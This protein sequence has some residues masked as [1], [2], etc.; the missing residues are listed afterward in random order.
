MR[1]GALT[2]LEATGELQDRYQVWLCRCD[3]GNEIKASTKRLRRVPD[4]SCGCTKID[5][6]RP[7]PIPCDLTGRRYGMLTV[8]RSEPSAKAL[9]PSWLCRCDCGNECY[10][11]SYSLHNGKRKSCG[12]LHR[13]ASSARDVDLTDQVF[14]RLTAIC[15]TEDRGRGGSVIWKCRCE[16]GAEINVSADSLV[17]GYYRSCGCIRRER[18]EKLHDT[19]TFV[20][21]TCVDILEKRKSRSDNTSGFRGVSKGPNGKW[22]VSIGMQN[23]RYYIGLFR[24][25]DDAVSARLRIEEALHDG[26]VEA[27]HAW[28][29]KAVAEQA[30]AAENPFYFNVSKSG[31]SFLIDTVFG[32][33]TVSAV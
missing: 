23:K 2:V 17:Q 15:P 16:C 3:C 5:A 14:G 25:F 6:L 9:H 12:C 30:W 19:M 27:Y 13:K 32:S 33:T 4:I 22:L 1:F 11:T 21:Q 24:D 29:R 20:E 7:A 26:F 10:V 18:Q 31:Q 28:Q 8:I